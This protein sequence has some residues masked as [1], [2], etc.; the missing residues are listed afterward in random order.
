MGKLLTSECFD[1]FLMLEAQIVTANSYTIDG[2]IQKDFYTQEEWEDESLSPD[3]ISDWNGMRPVVHSLIKGKHT[4]V[5]FQIILQLS[6]KD[7]AE[8]LPEQESKDISTLLC[9]IRYENGQTVLISGV[10]YR[11]FSM[12]KEP[13]R[14]WEKKLKD[15]LTENKIEFEET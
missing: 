10:S 9:T 8:V 1:H 2:H 3:K 6:V 7:R 5:R 4:P 15:F 12:D 14:V 11:S 13:E